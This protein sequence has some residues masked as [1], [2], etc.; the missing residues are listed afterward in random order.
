M[1]KSS[2]SAVGVRHIARLTGIRPILFDRYGG[3]NTTKLDDMQKMYLN[4]NLECCIPV[5]N[6][7]SLLSAI[8]T[9]SVA[10]RFYGKQ[11]ANLGMMVQA[12]VNIE[13]HKTEDSMLATICD[14]KGK[15]YTQS[16]P[17]ITVIGHVARLKGGIP[18]PKS[19]PMIPTG[20]S[21]TFVFEIQEN[22][23]VNS[24]TLIKMV[25]QGGIIGLGTFRPIFGRYRVEWLS[26]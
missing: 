24:E 19:R 11:G 26:A 12:F 2:V 23:T 6:V 8:N 15:I 18:N 16:D 3:T 17:R 14:D 4:E 13:A 21:V 22:P 25:E 20:W 9:P 1:V 7:F 10:K 5:L